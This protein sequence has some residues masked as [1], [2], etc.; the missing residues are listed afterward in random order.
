MEAVFK[1]IASETTIKVAKFIGNTIKKSIVQCVSQKQSTKVPLDDYVNRYNKSFYKEIHKCQQSPRHSTSSHV[2]R[3]SPTTYI[4]TLSNGRRVSI[5]TPP[6]LKVNSHVP[7]GSREHSSNEVNIPRTPTTVTGASTC[8]KST[9]TINKESNKVSELVQLYEIP[10][11]SDSLKFLNRN[12]VTNTPIERVVGVC[13]YKRSGKDSIADRLCE[14]AGY[15]KMRLS[16]PLKNICKTLFGFSSEQLESD[17]KE[18]VDE[19]WNATPRHIMQFV[20]TEIMQF[21]MQEISDKFNRQF[22][23]TKLIQDMEKDSHKWQRVVIPDIRFKHEHDL[24]KQIFGD[25][26]V[27]VKVILADHELNK[28]DDKHVSETEWESLH[29]DYLVQNNGTL[30][31]LYKKVDELVV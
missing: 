26:Y 21:K 10:P 7:N 31:E 9:Q 11:R 23:I 12:G 30:Q 4:Q 18:V 28:Q 6:P 5:S 2:S 8:H 29:H 17:L 1:S 19:R 15:H 27:L 13:G 20:G 24:L 16:D 22:W 14:K 3:M 25:R